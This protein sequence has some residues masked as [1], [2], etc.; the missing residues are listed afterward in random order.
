MDF[1]QQYA[2]KRLRSD[3]QVQMAITRGESAEDILRLIPRGDEDILARSCQLGMAFNRPDLVDVLVGLYHDQADK[4][5]ELL[6][7]AVFF[8]KI[9][10]I[11]VLRRRGASL[12]RLKAYGHELLRYPEPVQAALLADGDIRNFDLLRTTA[13]GLA[14]QAICAVLRRKRRFAELARVLAATAAFAPL[15]PLARVGLLREFGF[16]DKPRRTTG[17]DPK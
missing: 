15:D 4:A 16:G 11:G 8:G 3:I 17:P 14:P 13:Q 10:L 7:Q 9:P 2:T 12:A 1:E 6:P 5:A